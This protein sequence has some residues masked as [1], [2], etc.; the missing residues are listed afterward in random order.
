MLHELTVDD[1]LMDTLLRH[2]EDSVH[3]V[4]VTQGTMP[5]F[6][7]TSI[8]EGRRLMRQLSWP[9]KKPLNPRRE[10]QKAQRIARRK[11]RT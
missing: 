10:K 6:D 4:R 3:P 9:T 1:L 7:L 5:N 2:L 8:L 11:N